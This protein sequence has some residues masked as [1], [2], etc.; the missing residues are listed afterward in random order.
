[1]AKLDWSHVKSNF[2][3]P[4]GVYHAL[5]SG[6]EY[7]EVKNGKIALRVPFLITAPAQYEDKKYSE[8][9]VIGTDDDPDAEEAETWYNSPGAGGIKRL[10]SFGGEDFPEDTDDIPE[11]IEGWNVGFL[12]GQ[13][14]R[15][16]TGDLAN[17]IT[18]YVD[19]ADVDAFVEEPEE[20]ESPRKGRAAKDEDED[21]E[22]ED[23]EEPKA[24]SKAP[25]AK[26]ARR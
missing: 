8:L 10:L 3:Y 18:K 13:R 23:M 1:M 19:P 12:L 7:I 26:K 21:E 16:D 11:L 2:L 4:K 15:K 9:F 6:A 5:I 24:K 25:K 17:N 20:P 14:K 22:D